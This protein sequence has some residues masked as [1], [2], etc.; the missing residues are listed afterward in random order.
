MPFFPEKPSL[1][2]TIPQ[3]KTSIP[4]GLWM[5][6]RECGQL[7]YQKTLDKSLQVCPECGFHYPMTANARIDTLAD[8]GTFQEMWQEMTSVDVLSF[9]GDGSY[10]TKLEE[11]RAKTEL[12]EAVVC[13]VCQIGGIAS[14]LAVMDFRFM[15]ASMGSVVGEKI[16]RLMEY[17]IRAHKPVVVVTASGGARMQEGV[18]SL[19]QMAKTSAAVQRLDEAR[20]P[21]ITI[22][23]NP[24]TGGVTASFA[25]LGDVI[26]AEPKALIGFAGPRVIKETTRAELPESFQ[27]SEFLLE[28]G[29]IDAIVPRDRLKA[30]VTQILQAWQ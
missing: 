27:R 2:P 12:N 28:H 4:A 23:T 13:G 17:A 3:T 21:Y 16:T 29:F 18:V 11:T 25:S 5:K 22:L 24:T 7:I 9:A 14:T 6:C 26:L 30:T 1:M 20:L 8:Q 10:A 15:G 19:M